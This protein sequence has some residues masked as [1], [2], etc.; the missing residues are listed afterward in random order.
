MDWNYPERAF[1]SGLEAPVLRALWRAGTHLTG[2]Q[3]HRVTG[4]GTDRGVRYALARLVEHG[5]VTATPVGG[6]VLYDL[7]H[8]HLTYPAVDAAFRALDPW[9]QLATRLQALI[10]SSFGPGSSDDVTVAVFGSVAR[11]EAELGSD[12]DLL[13]VVPDV[14]E[15]A[16]AFTDQL[17]R[18]GRDWTGQL[19]QVYLTT[20]A[21]LA[22]AREADDPI[23]A[24]FLDDAKRLV[25]PDIKAHLTGPRR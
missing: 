19:V 25:G 6:S 24:S 12:L 20:P 7:N 14:D 5:I 16:H 21:L 2:A 22:T 1:G 3:V 18:H 10:R 23:V 17:D 13:V 9:N 4:T 8:E 15:R 11:G